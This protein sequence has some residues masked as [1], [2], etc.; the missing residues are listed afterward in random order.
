MVVLN[1]ELEEWD[2]APKQDAFSFGILS[3]F[4]AELQVYF[5]ND[6]KLDFWV[7]TR[8]HVILLVMYMIFF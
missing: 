8:V 7:I 1:I 6:I 4:S 2:G 5:V 3:Y